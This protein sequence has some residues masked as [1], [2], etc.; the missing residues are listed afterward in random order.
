MSSLVVPSTSTRE[1]AAMYSGALEFYC[2][3]FN[4]ELSKQATSVVVTEVALQRVKKHPGY[5]D[6]VVAY[7]ADVSVYVYRAPVLRDRLAVE[8]FSNVMQ[9][10]L[11][12]VN[13]NVTV[14]LPF[15]RTLKSVDK[16]CDVV[17]SWGEKNALDIY[18]RVYVTPS[19]NDSVEHTF[20][21]DRQVFVDEYKLNP[22]LQGTLFEQIVLFVGDGAQ[23]AFNSVFKPMSKK[24]LAPRRPRG[25]KRDPR[26]TKRRRIH[27]G[28]I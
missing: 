13:D 28:K 26:G 27:T 17:V 15:V 23:T 20:T 14:I 10:V 21:Y 18:V 24:C 5:V 22:R 8:E 25:K 3:H 9:N 1:D 4:N 6:V 2:A 16:E 12:D 7:K 11:R 19:Q